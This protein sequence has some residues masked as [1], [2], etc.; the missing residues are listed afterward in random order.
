MKR[1][2]FIVIL[3]A[4]ISS[5]QT[6][7]FEEPNNGDENTSSK[8]E[9]TMY[10]KLTGFNVTNLDKLPTENGEE[11]KATTQSNATDHLLLGIYD[12]EGELVD[13]IIY[14]NKTDSNISYGTFSHTLKYGK[15]T[16]LALG[17]N[18]SQQCHVQSLDSIYFSEDWVP[19]TFICRQNVIVNESYSE[20]RTLS[21]KRCIARFVLTF[22]DNIIP[23]NLSKFVVSFSGAGN[24]LSSETK[25]CTQ[26]QDFSRE[27]PVTIDP[28]KITS[29]TSYCFLPNDSAGISIDITAHDIN[30][31]TISQ[32]IFNEV[33]MKINYSTQ[34]TGNFF[35]Y[36]TATGSVIFET[37]YD[38]EIN[39]EF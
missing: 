24:T 34:Y 29:L 36:T 31:D 18:G 32:R 9:K 39:K 16:I 37:E 15:Y 8:G 1:F 23:E 22:K 28:S 30:G 11:T 33:P 27:I 35:D 26:I 6:M 19:N 3:I 12:M 14:Q 17:W 13:S 7:T 2:K 21:L 5:C 20:T 10:F 25:H 38:G 4:L